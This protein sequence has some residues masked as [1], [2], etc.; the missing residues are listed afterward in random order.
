MGASRTFSTSKYLDPPDTVLASA[1]AWTLSG[2]VYLTSAADNASPFLGDLTASSMPA[3]RYKS[4]NWQ[5]YAHDGTAFFV[6]AQTHST[7]VALNTWAN[8]AIVY[9]G[10]TTL[11]LYTDGVAD[12]ARTSVASKTLASSAA[13]RIG[14]HS[15]GGSANFFP[16]E[17]ANVQC[18][19]RALSAEEVMESTYRP[20]SIS[21]NLTGWWPCWNGTTA[22]ETDLSGAGND[23][24]SGGDPPESSNGPP[25]SIG[26]GPALAIAGVAAAPGV[27]PQG[28]LGHPLYG[29]LAGPIGP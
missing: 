4:G 29:P 17:I 19:D 7:A 25:Y 1:T 24:T 8:I 9:D 27:R 3:V 21:A 23:A 10:S 12:T 15:I 18:W 14:G 20:G 16:G 22:T 28:P 26:Y 11:P 5:W 13:V 6:T 2:W